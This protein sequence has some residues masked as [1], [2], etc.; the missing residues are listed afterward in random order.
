MM[1]AGV[2][3]VRVRVSYW[4]SAFR[5]AVWQALLQAL[6]ELPPAVALAFQAP[7]CVVLAFLEVYVRL[8]AA[9]DSDEGGPLAALAA[10]VK[11]LLASLEK[12]EP[13][14]VRAFAEKRLQGLRSSPSR[15]LDRHTAPPPTPGASAGGAGGAS[16]FSSPVA[17]TMMPQ[18]Q[19]PRGPRLS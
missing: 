9:N 2:K 12:H 3:L 17:A 13:D 4:G 11:A 10:H 8:L 19:A 1:P 18:Q 15:V 5:P 16:A 7:Q 6:M 14:A